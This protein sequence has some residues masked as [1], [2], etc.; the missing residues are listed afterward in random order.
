MKKRRSCLASY[1]F[2]FDF[3]HTVLQRLIIVDILVLQASIDFDFFQRD[4]TYGLVKSRDQ[5]FFVIFVNHIANNA[6]V[7]Q[8]NN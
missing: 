7:A 5:F 4:R 2:N 6:G 8:T 1:L 3:F